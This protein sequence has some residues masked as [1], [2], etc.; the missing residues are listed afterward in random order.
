EGVWKKG[1]TRFPYLVRGALYT[2]EIPNI[3]EDREAYP[4]DSPPAEFL[5]KQLIKERSHARKN[6]TTTGLPFRAIFLKSSFK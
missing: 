4:H 3:F 5:K 1:K 2:L 6:F